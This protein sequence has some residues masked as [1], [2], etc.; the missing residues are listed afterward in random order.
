MYDLKIT[1]G[2]IVD[3]T[4]R[5]AFTGDVAV[6]D[7]RIVAIGDCPGPAT[8][9][10]DAH[11]AHVLPGFVDI[12]T[13]YDGQVSWDE[14]LSPS[15]TLGVTTCVMGSCG[16][17]FAPVRPGEEQRLV[18][19]MEG[20]EDIPGS[21]LAE[22]I[23]W[24]WE[25]FEDYMGAIGAMPHAIDF[26]VQVPHDPLR[27]YVMGDRA[28]ADE[29][30][31]DVEI[32]EMRRLLRAALEA[33]AAGFS[34]GR[35]DNHRTAR[36]AAT[37]ASEV[38][39]RELTG[40]AEAFVGL[41]HGV[42]QAVSDFDMMRGPE[43]FDPEFD[44]IEAMAEATGGRPVSISTMQRDHAP[45]QWRQILARIER[46][47][48]RGLDMRCQVGA[49]GIGVLIGLEATFHP[50]MG[51]PSYK[52]IAELPLAERVA[53]MRDPELRA[54]MLTETSD[55]VAGDSTPIPPL[56]DFFLAN[57]GMVAMRLFPMKAVPDYEPTLMQS[58]AGE[59]SRAGK[60]VLAHIYDA[61]LE[62]EGKALL[63]FPVYNYTGMSLDAVREMLT[64]PRALMGLG[65]AGAHV[66]TVCDASI[67]TYLLTHW[68]R[69][70]A[71]GLPLEQVVKMQAHDTARF[72]GLTDRGTL[73]VGMR[74]DLNVIDLAQ[75]RLLR[76]Q[77]QRDLPA[78]GRRLVQRAEGY[79]A[80]L[81]AGVP[82]AE[83]GVMTGARPGRLVRLGPAGSA[84]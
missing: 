53:R 27:M 80:T 63:Y 43:R 67:P 70:R 76:P 44:L 16:V 48:E 58:M 36:G 55:K 18:E 75:L 25:S 54:R 74:A 2:T 51:F 9:T 23:P 26:L 12:H 64:H 66:G 39:A 60:P 81:V 77:M 33:G 13:H 5:P 82:I 17:G 6:T 35:S 50:F 3:G 20:V 72:I 30:A 46:A 29:A 47:V 21:A 37:P 22:G 31:T 71:A 62:D 65:D 49:R 45:N 68:A 69:D 40:I 34:T 15:S 28:V 4:G 78:G 8:R 24:G 1:G 61:L 57:L 83:D 79:R 7:G 14:E 42:L 38:D 11:G 10:I 84:A 59:A 41:D 32:A 73:E 52:A 56:V 19:L